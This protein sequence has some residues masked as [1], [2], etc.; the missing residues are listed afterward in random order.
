MKKFLFL[1]TFATC[2]LNLFS[3]DNRIPVLKSDGT[4]T[5]IF[6]SGGNLAW[7]QFANDFGPGA[8]NFEYFDSVF[9]A[10]E[11][12]GGNAMRLWVH[13]NGAN[14][15]E[16]DSTG[17]CTGLEESHIS[18]MERVLNLAYNHNIVLVLSLWSFDMLN[19]RDY[20]EEVSERGELILTVEENIQAY[21]DN[22]L[23]PM[24]E[25]FKDHPA[26]GSW[27]IFNEPEGMSEEFGWSHTNHVPMSVIQ[28]FVNRCAGAIHETDSDALV[29]NGV[30]AMYAMTDILTSSDSTYKNYYSDEELIAAGGDSMGILDFYQVH[31]YDWM[32]NDISVMHHSADYW[33]LDKAIVVG[34]FFPLDADTLSWE[35]YYDLLY[36]NDYAGALAWQWVG[37]DGSTEPYQ[38]N[39]V[40]LMES[41]RDYDD[42][43]IEEGRNRFPTI[44]TIDNG[45]FDINSGTISNY[46]NLDEI[47]SDP[48]GDELTFE[49]EKN[50][51]TN[52][53]TVSINSS[54]GVDLT[55][56]PDWT[57]SATIT[58]KVTDSE[59]LTASCEFGI[60]VRKSGTGNLALY[61]TTVYTSSNEGGSNGDP[62]AATDGD[63][64]SRWSSQYIDSSWY[65]VDLGDVYE[66]N[67]VIL[68]WEAAYGQQYLIQVS[69][70]STTWT[71][72]H[73]EYSGDGDIDDISFDSVEA[74]YV[75]MNG[76]LR[77]TEWGY[78]FYEFEVYGTGGGADSIP[79]EE[80]AIT[81][82]SITL[83]A[84]QTY[85]LDAEYT[86]SNATNQNTTW[87]SDNEEVATVSSSGIV[88]AHSTGI[89]NITATTQ[90]GGY[91]GTT[92]VNVVPDSVVLQYT[93]TINISGSGSVTIDPEATIFDEE[94]V[95]TL[96]AVPDSFNVFVEW[97]GD[98]TDTTDTITIIM[99]SD[100]TITAV[101]Y[102]TDNTCDNPVSI[103]VPISQDGAGEYCWVTT[104]EI[105]Y[106]SS[107][108][109]E[110]VEI[111]GVDYSN[112]WSS[113]L[114]DAINGKWYIYYKGNF[115][116]S[117]FEAASTKSTQPLAGSNQDNTLVFYPNP[118]SSSINLN[119]EKPELVNTIEVIDNLGRTILMLDKTQIQS[120]MN[121]GESLSRGIYYVKVNTKSGIKTNIISKN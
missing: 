61:R 115:S 47:S 100:K 23:I 86:P 66:V 27:E 38:S 119:I 53:V 3:Q 48:D 69:L 57:G 93:L 79:L 113:D 44:G 90:D 33:E 54:N 10:F 11:D 75:K 112:T 91:T 49:V 31:Y 92:I 42:I 37:E 96:I 110:L 5:D 60:V 4:K 85:T 67:N 41:I 99:D 95:V 52:L 17:Y 87:T 97:T 76:V 12:A 28:R 80:F 109:M 74:R 70:D 118:F 77:G 15:P 2:L 29:T 83:K 111:N 20:D 7:D 56:T 107:W 26:V 102:P 108:N 19:Y 24:V 36:N 46:V 103:S 32:S 18:D 16:I 39:M 84:D 101:F 9:T 68:Y 120:D 65:F 89:A 81:Q 14:N 88:T 35:T 58:L 50:T 1:L 8:T 21:I 34:E 73:T 22:A 71:T 98:L 45:V 40:A 94:S 51:N 78:S 116:W 62:L 6:L 59:G 82:D 13:I 117:H 25:A 114:P 106:V 104:D 105:S 63:Y 30:W 121:F 72:V 43:L 64:D 55:F